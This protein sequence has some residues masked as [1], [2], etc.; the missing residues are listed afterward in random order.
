MTIITF[1]KE[2]ST[3]ISPPPSSLLQPP[4]PQ[5]LK[6]LKRTIGMNNHTALWLH[7]RG[8][9]ASSRVYSTM[10][11]GRTEGHAVFFFRNKEW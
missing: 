10:S 8:K 6:I 9:Y 11:S 4:S 5:A 1:Q 7:D 3:V 2:L